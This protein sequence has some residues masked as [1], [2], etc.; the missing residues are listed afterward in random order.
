[1]FSHLHQ[2]PFEVCPGVEA[3][4][5]QSLERIDLALAGIEASSKFEPVR[6]LRLVHEFNQE[7][8]RFYSSPCLGAWSYYHS[9]VDY[10]S[11]LLKVAPIIWLVEVFHRSEIYLVVLLVFGSWFGIYCLFWVSKRLSNSSLV[12][13]ASLAVLWFGLSAIGPSLPYADFRLNVFNTFALVGVAQFLCD[14][15]PSARWARALTIEVAA[16]LVFASHALLL[17]FLRLPSTRLDATAVILCV[18][19]VAAIRW[20]LNVCRRAV[21]LIILVTATQWPYQRFSRTLLGPVSAVNSAASEEFKL[22][23]AVQFLDERPSHFG[24]F[25]L[26]HNFTWVMDGDYYLRQLSAVS[27]F[28]HGYP[29][30][31]RHFLIET[32]RHHAA[33]FPNAWWIRFVVQVV[34]LDELSYGIYGRHQKLGTV[35]LWFAVLLGFTILLGG[36]RLS[37][38]WPFVGLIFWETFGL[39]TFLALMHVHNIYMLKG[40]PILWS[41]LPCATY[42]VAREGLRE[43]RGRRLLWRERL[44]G[45]ARSATLVAAAVAV[46]ILVGGWVSREVKKE[47]HVT[48]IWR[49]I[50]VASVYKDAYLSP[51][52]V[53]R[54][55]DAI[56]RLGGEEPGTV[57]MYGAW[58]L[59]GYLERLNLYQVVTGQSISAD[60]VKQLEFEL[61]KRALAEGPDNPHFYAYARYFNDPDWPRV[62][63][64][65][66]ARF[67]DHP[68]SVMMSWFLATEGASVPGV[69]AARYRTVYESAVRNQLRESVSFRPGFRAIPTLTAN[70]PAMVTTDDGVLTTA[71]PGEVVSVEPFA[72]YNTDRLSVGLFLK[73]LSG[74]LGGELVDMA[75]Q[76]LAD[77]PLTTPTD[78]LSYR[79]WHFQDL[80]YAIPAVKGASA[81]LKLRAG[82]QGARFVLRDLYPLIENP[83]WFR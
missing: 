7:S 68:Y 11:W 59:F 3:L 27:A 74:S 32:V 69:D 70:G 35:V 83:R 33:E 1:M 46:S 63:Q 65:G 62:F 12:G 56:H 22:V 15:P 34:Y 82:S 26:D 17:M 8:Q 29:A 76:H 41:A 57:S 5:A 31:G 37:S 44:T 28:H 24:N 80:P 48:R 23:N 2:R 51:D 58:A 10:Q 14:L 39:H 43:A 20:D 38:A 73:V 9:Y 42:V 18:F 60:R 40:V 30:W 61:Y 47:I 36:R 55:V 79:A 53:A 78:L 52:D 19:A 64:E 6:L 21:L 71:L 49:A 54:E 75:G 13:F 77:L 72:A 67:P 50:H 4:H 66:L 25:I 81:R 45:T 16:G